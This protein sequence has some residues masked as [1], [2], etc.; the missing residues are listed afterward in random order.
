MNRIILAIV[1]G[2]LTFGGQ[3]YA[4]TSKSASFDVDPVDSTAPTWSAFPHIDRHWMLDTDASAADATCSRIASKAVRFA[5]QM[6]AG[7]SA[8]ELL[9]SLEGNKSTDS[10]DPFK[11]MNDQEA[12]I[13]ETLI[14]NV[15]NNYKK[16]KLKGQ[17]D[18]QIRSA[19]DTWC[20]TTYKRVTE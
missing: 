7:T 11:K 9:K 16:G 18:D 15:W 5:G 13:N 6:K 19:Y 14:S 8:D 10:N 3:V 4:Q 1:A 20:K 12:R 17:S 2:L